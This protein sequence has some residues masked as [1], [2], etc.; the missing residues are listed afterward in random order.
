MGSERRRFGLCVRNGV[1]AG[2]MVSLLGVVSV[3]EAQQASLVLKDSDMS[4]CNRQQNEWTLTKTNDATTQPVTSGTTVN[5]TVTATKT[6]AD[7]KEICAVGYVSVTNGGS[8]PATIGNIVVNLQR[9][10]GNKWVS[11]SVDVA[12]A[13]SGDAATSANIV[14]NASQELAPGPTYVISGAKGTFTENAASGAIEFTDANNNSIWAITPQQT[15]PAGQTVNLFFKAAFSNTILNVPPGE[16]LRTEVI[17]SFGNAGGRGGS[18]ASASSIDVNGNGS[19]DTDEANV[20]SVPTRLTK[21]LPA[22]DKCNDTVQLADSLSVASGARYSVESDPSGLLTGFAISESA[23]YQLSATVSGS[24]TVT[25][26]VTLKGTDTFVTVLVP[27]G[28]VDPVTGA[29]ILEPRQIACCTGVSLTVSSSVTVEVPISLLPGDYCSYTQGGYGQVNPRTGQPSGA[30]AVLLSNN[31]AS[32]YPSGVE[33]GIV[34]A[35]GFSMKFTSASA[36][37]AYLPA[38]GTAAALTVDLNNP[39]STSSG[40]FGGQ[41]L[42]LQLNVD[43]S[44][45]GVTSN[46]SGKL[47]DLKFAN[48]AATSQL[49]SWTLNAVQAAALNGKTVRQV[50]VNANTTLGGGALP[51]YV[52]S[53]SDLNQL[54]TWLNESFDNCVPTA[55]AINYLSR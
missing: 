4:F 32:V 22:L 19:I 17:V 39:T 18:G 42:T 27:T 31:F 48:L 8:A 28:A 3:A 54:V 26:T 20:R 34:G 37:A 49:N 36:V 51:A 2:V 23:T 25:N 33:V 45:A 30:P 15:I 24:G 11:A 52:G 9:K 14:A 21:T 6:T 35:G 16:S 53:I 7:L 5:W 13:T 41:V 40:V 55:G 29:A 44:D 50:L 1:L 10:N 47:G 12:D 46:V 43:F 38:G